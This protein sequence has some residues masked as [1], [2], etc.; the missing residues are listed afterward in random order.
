M[1]TQEGSPPS[2]GSS[3]CN[4]LHIATFVGL[5]VMTDDQ[6][7]ERD[8]I[9]NRIKL[10]PTI[11]PKWL[12]ERSEETLVN[13]DYLTEVYKEA[14]R[15]RYR[16]EGRPGAAEDSFGMTETP[17]PRSSSPTAMARSIPFDASRRARRGDLINIRMESPEADTPE[18]LD[19]TAVLFRLIT[20]LV[21]FPM[22]SVTRA[23]A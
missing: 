21:P 4:T 17:N 7:E 6:A 2:A 20:Y 18:G 12:V 23:S 8:K 14:R 19:S 1:T 5:V 3:L 9:I 11:P 13:L 22:S 16:K 15:L 10:T